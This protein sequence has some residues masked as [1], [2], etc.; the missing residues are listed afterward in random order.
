[1]SA[2][3]G[4][5]V[6]GLTGNIATGKSVIRRMLEHLGA[7]GIDA[8]A[9]SHRAMA[10]GAPGYDPV[11]QHFGQ[12]ILRPDGQIGRTKL[13]RIAF[14]DPDALKQLE[15]I[16]HPFVRQAIDVLIR[17]STQP[18]IV[19]EAIKLLEGG[20]SNLC[21]SIWVAQA[22]PETQYTRLLQKRGFSEADARVRITSQSPQAEKVAAADVVINNN[23]SFEAAWQKVVAA[24]NAIAPA[25][26]EPTPAEPEKIE[27]GQL[28]VRRAGPKQADEIASFITRFNKEKKQVTR[29]DVMAAFGEKAFMV[30]YQ[31]RQMV[32]LV[33]WQVENLVARVVD[34]YLNPRLSLADA[35]PGLM[36][37]V[38]KASRELQS[39]AALLFLPVEIARHDGVW[40][41]LGYERRDT[42][43]L[44]VRAWEEAANESYVDG[45]EM[46]FKQL[47]VDRVLRPI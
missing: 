40:K 27:P 37:E 43:S 2:W 14:A 19:I 15:T 44:G 41:S 6:I 7:Y 22:S 32:G 33:G 26:P 17:R 1:M 20:L 16:I 39:E 46:L 23:G 18:V 34:F 29:A 12:W 36:A 47:R 5:Y 28:V 31:D 9:L 24:W 10:K 30:M 38:E 42:E 8:D 25:A 3:P 21:D 13:G 4:K 11:V 35:A 45:S